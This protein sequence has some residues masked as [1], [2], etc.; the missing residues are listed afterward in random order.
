M[1]T[2]EDK[3]EAIGVEWGLIFPGPGRTWFGGPE[4]HV[5]GDS[6]LTGHCLGRYPTKSIV[7]LG[8]CQGHVIIDKYRKY[9]LA[10]I[11]D[12]TRI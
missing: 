11:V 2:R 5:G 9:I 4:V 6:V 1:A 12:V 7:F 3:T 8:E 10:I